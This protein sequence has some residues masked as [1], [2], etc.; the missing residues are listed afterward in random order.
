MNHLKTRL[1]SFSHAFRGIAAGLRSEWNMRVHAVAAILVV[2]AG[3]AHGCSRIEWL[4]LIGAMALVLVSELFNTAL[5]R[6]CDYA[7]EGRRHPLIKAAKDM[8]AGAVTLAAIAAAII[9]ALVFLG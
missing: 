1:A 6:L 4:A 2:I 5:E 3:F 9:G 7:C 8:A